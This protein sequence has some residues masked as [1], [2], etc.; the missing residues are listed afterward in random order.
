[1]GEGAKMFHDLFLFVTFLKR[2]VCECNFGIK[3]FEFR[4]DFDVAVG[5][6]KGC[7]YGPAFNFVSV[8]LDVAT[9]E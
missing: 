7:S 2:R 3:A 5:L 8:L 9:T 4:N 1:M 6:G